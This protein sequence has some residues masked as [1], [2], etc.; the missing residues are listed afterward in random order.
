V[1]GFSLLAID[2]FFTGLSNPSTTIILDRGL[3]N[4]PSA[5][6]PE[7]DDETYSEVDSGMMTYHCNDPLGA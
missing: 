4:L 2:K 5:M 7:T 6:N 3:L 1:S